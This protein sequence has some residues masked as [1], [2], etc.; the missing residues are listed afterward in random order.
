MVL[1]LSLSTT[2]P[3]I[4]DERLVGSFFFQEK[5]YGIIGDLFSGGMVVQQPA[6]SDS[7]S[8]NAQAGTINVKLGALK[9]KQSSK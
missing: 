3:H 8:A 6:L 5:G 1:S 2:V 4:H 9:V 7:D